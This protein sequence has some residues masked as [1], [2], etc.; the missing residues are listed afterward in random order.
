[1][2]SLYKSV[3]YPDYQLV[4]DQACA[5]FGF[6]WAD[7]GSSVNTASCD[8][9]SLASPSM[10]VLKFRSGVQVDQFLTPWPSDNPCQFS[11]A[12]EFALEWFAIVISLLVV[13]WGGKLI[14]KL[15]DSHHDKE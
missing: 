13:V 10:S 15:F 4:K 7:A 14:V 9:A 5:S 12:S 2:G 1:M 11:G 6:T 3:C 8:V